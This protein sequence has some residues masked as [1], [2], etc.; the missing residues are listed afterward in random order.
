LKAHVDEFEAEENQIRNEEKNKLEKE[1]ISQEEKAQFML[2]NKAENQAVFEGEKELNFGCKN[3]EKCGRIFNEKFEGKSSQ[4]NS[5]KMEEKCFVKG[6]NA[7]ENYG[8]FQEQNTSLSWAE[9][10]EKILAKG[11]ENNVAEHNSRG[12]KEEDS[13]VFAFDNIRFDGSNF[14]LSVKPQLDEIFVCYP[15]EEVLNGLVPNSSWVRINTPDGY[16]VVGLILDGDA[17]SYI[18]YG[19]PSTDRNM[20]PTEIADFAVWLSLGG[21]EGRGYWLI[22][23]DALTG[24]CLK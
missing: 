22:Y 24:K 12:E 2:E 23:Q 6:L 17:V 10:A 1:Q 9:R 4:N 8:N 7:N 3:E 15:E 20:P 5:E 13:K 16:Y 19:V 14:Y 11:D 21:G 18:C